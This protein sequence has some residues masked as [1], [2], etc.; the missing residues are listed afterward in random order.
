MRSLTR[1]DEEQ[2]QDYEQATMNH[3]QECNKQEK[4]KIKKKN[5]VNKKLNAPQINFKINLIN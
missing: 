3:T 2:E 1:V 4:N 5:Q